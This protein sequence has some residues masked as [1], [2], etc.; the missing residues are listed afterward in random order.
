MKIYI[1]HPQTTS[2]H[3]VKWRLEIPPRLKKVFVGW[4]TTK[5]SM[6]LHSKI[7]NCHR[8]VP[9]VDMF[10]KININHPQCT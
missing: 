9:R 1:N 5:G 6:F 10:M 8:E 7:I 3:P 2:F 4:G